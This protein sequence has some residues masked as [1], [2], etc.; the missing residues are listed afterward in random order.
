MKKIYVALLLGWALATQAVA[1]VSTTPPDF[2]VRTMADW[3][4]HEALVV[5]WRSYPAILTEIV[6]AAVSECKVIVICP[7]QDSLTSAQ[8]RLTGNGISL[9]NV[10]MLVTPVNS[11]WMRDYGHNCVYAN[12]VDSLVLVDWIYNRNR[13]ADDNLPV[14]LG[15]HLGLPVFRTRGTVR[16]GQHRRQFYVRRHGDGLR[17]RV[18]FSQQQPNCRR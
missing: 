11:V 12:G 2:P 15:Q 1:Q 5:A 7:N 4:E 8:N 18:G 17:Q 3:E 9:A 16:S 6:R 13:P 14:T 10:E